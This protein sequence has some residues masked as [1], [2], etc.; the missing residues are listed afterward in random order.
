MS[1][2]VLFLQANFNATIFLFDWHCSKTMYIKKKTFAHETVY[3]ILVLIPVS[4]GV[5][6]P[7]NF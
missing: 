4:V 7:F 1:L 6:I 2:N 5:S 3:L